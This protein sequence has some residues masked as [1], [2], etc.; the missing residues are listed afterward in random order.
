MS[1]LPPRTGNRL[2]I[3][4]AS[5]RAAAGSALR[6]G[7]TPVC[8]DMFADLDLRQMAQVVPVA[9]YPAGLPAAVAELPPLPWIY[10][11]ALEN[12]PRIVEQLNRRHSLWGNDAAILGKARDPRVWERLLKS[13]RLP[14]LPLRDAT[15]PPEPDGTWLQK[16]LRGAA[17]RGI[18][19]W[20]T[21]ARAEGTAAGCY[22]QR[23]QRG[24]PLSAQFLA[25]PGVTWLLGITRQLIGLPEVHAAPFAY[26]GTLAPWPLGAAATAAVTAIGRCLAAG[27]GLR[28]LFGCDFVLHEEVPWLTELNPRYTASIEILEYAHHVAHLDWHRRACLAFEQSR[29]DRFFE[30]LEREIQSLPDPATDETVGKLIFFAKHALTTPD[31]NQVA[32]ERFDPHVLPA[33]ADIPTAGTRVPAGQPICTL[34]GRAATAEACLADL[35]ARAR[36]FEETL[37]TA[38]RGD[39]SDSA[40]RSS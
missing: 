13:A 39:A 35:V 40:D 8:G 12:H 32:S 20:D 17:G 38:P 30:E 1:A 22:F 23:Y 14:S 28:G 25:G 18:G 21:A 26:C 36:R 37:L 11:G 29:P 15:H 34:L 19:V 4:G 31:M 27:C 16:P 7:L 33:W 9:D 3:V 2:L 6:A 5:T 10:T 24:I